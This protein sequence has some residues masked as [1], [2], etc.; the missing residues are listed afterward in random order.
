MDD[1]EEE[2][3]ATEQRTESAEENTSQAPS[4]DIKQDDIDKLFQKNTENNDSDNLL[5]PDKLFADPNSQEMNSGLALILGS[6][7]T[8]SE[9][10]PILDVVFDRLVRFL[11]TSLRNFTAENVDV[12]CSRIESVRLADYLNNLPLPLL[13]GVF[14][15]KQWDTPALISIDNNLT[16]SVIEILLGG[17]KIAPTKGRPEGR[18]YTSLERALIENLIKVILDDF[19][20]AFS[21]ICDVDFVFERLEINPRFATIVHEKNATM[22]ISFKLE[23]DERGGHFDIIIPYSS[24]EP[25]RDLLLQNF[26][27]EKFGRDPIWE[28]HLA[29]RIKEANIKLQAA[30]PAE[31]FSLHEVLSWKVGSQISLSCNTSTQVGMYRDDYCVLTGRMGQKNGHVAIMVNNI[32]FGKE[33]EGES[34]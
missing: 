10:L 19:T 16:T 33:K 5:D 7:I 18:S 26:M 30:L 13:M 27:G 22:K 20:S 21:P 28:N 24:V 15:A 31:Q 25:I 9:R 32:L 34:L 29:S 2:K 23:M 3:E 14:K 11:T 12:S 17:R 6:G 1:T 4:E 8:Q